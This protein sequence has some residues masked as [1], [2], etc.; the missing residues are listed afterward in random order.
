MPFRICTIA[1]AAAALAV[2]FANAVDAQA[3]ARPGDT[4]AKLADTIEQRLEACAVCHGKQGEGLGAR[5]YYPRIGGKP[6]K[7]LYLQLVNFREGRRNYPQ[8]VY[9]MRYMSDAYLMEI[10]EF[11]AKQKPQF[12]TPIKP[13][14]TSADLARGEALVRQGDPAKNVPACAA[15]HGE[16]L[17][18]MLPAIPGLIGLHSDYINAQLGHWR[19]STRVAQAPDCMR[20]IAQR[21]SPADASAIAR[22]LASLPGTA[23]TLPAPES[24]KKLPLEC[25]S[26]AK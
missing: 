2:S 19:T 15:C 26:Q 21:L 24:P 22:W 13:A 9:L 6:A 16:A 8:M 20:E 5:E 14:A 17:T 23:T 11:Y 7:Y 12:A 25:G 10:A 4:Q 3:P 1:I 18:G